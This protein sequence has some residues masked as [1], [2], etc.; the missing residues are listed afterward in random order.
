MPWY[1]AMLGLLCSKIMSNHERI[2]D[3][4]IHPNANKVPHQATTPPPVHPLP[5]AV[6]LSLDWQGTSILHPL[7]SDII[8]IQFTNNNY[9]T[10]TSTTNNSTS[11]SDCNITNESQCNIHDVRW[12][13]QWLGGRRRRRRIEIVDAAAGGVPVLPT[14]TNLSV[15]VQSEVVCTTLDLEG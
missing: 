12:W 13:W 2:T 10:S 7:R 14:H 9:S 4:H 1:D 15:L 3:T 11:T 8:I 6:T 5:V